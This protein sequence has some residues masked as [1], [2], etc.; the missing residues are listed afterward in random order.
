MKRD[1]RAL[2]AIF[3]FITSH[4]ALVALHLENIL[5]VLDWERNG[6]PCAQARARGINFG[7]CQAVTPKIEVYLFST[8]LAL[9]VTTIALL[10]WI[11]WKPFKQ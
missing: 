10:I 3:G 5:R 4:V 6:D 7:F 9:M 1:W 2:A 11:F 8:W